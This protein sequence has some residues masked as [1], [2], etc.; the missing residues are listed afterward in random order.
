MIAILLMVVGGILAI[1]GFLG[2]LALMIEPV[3]TMYMVIFKRK[4]DYVYY[5]TKPGKALLQRNKKSL[6]GSCLFF[7]I[8]GILL[9]ALGFFLKFSPR[10]L[11]SL[12]SKQVD[13][14]TGVGDAES[15]KGIKEAVNAA[16]NY[17]D[18]AGEEYYDYLIIHGTTVQYRDQKQM[19]IEEFE[20][21]LEGLRK[22]NGKRNFYL[23]DDFASAQT[24]HR[25]EQLIEAG[26]MEY[27]GGGSK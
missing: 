25:V 18:E 22:Q 6:G 7:L 14:G 9:F 3:H 13:S 4:D 2:L 24:F 1:A 23:V 20:G 16:G 15:D 21:F 17:V 8:V 10:G 27:P 12:F 19:T 5:E 26:G 11:D